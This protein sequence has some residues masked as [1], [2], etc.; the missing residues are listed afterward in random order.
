[1]AVENSTLIYWVGKDGIYSTTKAE[2]EV[3]VKFW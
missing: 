1:M 3:K 2:R